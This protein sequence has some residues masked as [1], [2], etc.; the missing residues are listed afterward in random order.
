[1]NNILLFHIGMPKTGTTA[2]QKFLYQNEKNL[3]AY[4]WCYPNLK[5]ELP[6]IREY[7]LQTE[8]NGDLF[9]NYRPI[10]DRAPRVFTESWNKLWKQVLKHL[11]SENVIISSEG[12]VDYSEI[13]WTDIKKIYN[14]IK[15]IV[16]LRRQD[17]LIESIWNEF[18]KDTNC[19]DKSFEEFIDCDRTIDEWN[20]NFIKKLDQVSSVIG[21]ENLIVRIYEKGQFEGKRH[22]IESD[23]LYSIGIDPDW[24][25]LSKCNVE[26]PRLQ[27]N[28]IEI[29]KIFNSVIVNRDLNIRQQIFDAFINLSQNFVEENVEAGYFTLT[30]RKEFLQQFTLSN[31]QVAC[32]YLHREDGVLFYDNE[33]NFPLYEGHQCSLFEEDLIRVFSTL[34]CDQGTELQIL[35]KRYYV[36]AKKLLMQNIKGRKLLLFGAGYWCREL[37]ENMELLPILIADNDEKKSAE[38]IGGIKVIYAKTV[39]N[40]SDYY[41]IVT[42]AVTDEIEQ[43]LESLGLKKEDDYV[44]AKEYLAY[45]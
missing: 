4:G 20:L 18:I 9:Y 7:R 25:V 39:T 24:E 32:K 13:F 40:W 21:K 45:G 44:L 17:R 38:R 5:E 41:V 26:N 43:Q 30:E 28:F 3:K 35:K 29:K 16:Y 8:R 22:T 33:M 14:N 15:V 19:L 6:E 34:I 31:E 23:F 2:I 1:M 27:G 12:L 10:S 11:E 37:M 36:L 42:C